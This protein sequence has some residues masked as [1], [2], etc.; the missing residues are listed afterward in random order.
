MILF[1]QLCHVGI[2]LIPYVV[3]RVAQR[4]ERPHTDLMIF[5]SQVRIPLWDVRAGPSDETV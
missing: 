2:Y 4:L 5:T 1:V 3:A